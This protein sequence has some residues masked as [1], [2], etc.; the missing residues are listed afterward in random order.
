MKVSAA[1]SSRPI[2]CPYCAYQFLPECMGVPTAKCGEPEKTQSEPDDFPI[3]VRDFEDDLLPRASE[4]PPGRRKETRPSERRRARFKD[5]GDEPFPEE[6]RSGRRRTRPSDEGDEPLPEERSPRRKLSKSTR[7]RR[8]RIGVTLHFSAVSIWATF[9]AIMFLVTVV[10]LIG[11]IKTSRPSIPYPRGSTSGQL[12]SMVFSGAIV[13]TYL[14]VGGMFLAGSF[15]CAFIPKNRRTSSKILGQISLGTAIALAAS[16]VIEI[17]GPLVGAMIFPQFL[18]PFAL[19][20]VV[21]IWLAVF[22]IVSNIVLFLLFFRSAS[23]DMDERGLAY[24][25]E[26]LLVNYGILLGAYI[27]GIVLFCAGAS[28]KLGVLAIFSLVFMF[29]VVIA[30]WWWIALYILTILNF[31]RAITT[32]IGD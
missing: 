12:L 1:L 21:N 6:R 30:S 28:A 11:S 15:F 5:E 16:L 9:A 18:A 29:G 14:A 22:L 4:K 23:K 24:S 27:F 31:R 3:E 32:H 26:R 20:F 17:T 19:L 8:V 25:F 2:K 10:S 13:L 7:W